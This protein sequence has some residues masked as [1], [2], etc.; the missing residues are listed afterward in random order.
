MGGLG[1]QAGN[2]GIPTRAGSQSGPG[3]MVS[4]VV[5]PRPSQRR[6]GV[7]RSE[8]GRAAELWTLLLVRTPTLRKIAFPAAGH[9]TS[10]EVES[11]MT[12]RSGV[13]LV[14]SLLAVPIVAVQVTEA[15]RSQQKV[16]ET[17]GRP[18]GVAGKVL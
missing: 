13:R 5:G 1:R 2:G 17:F 14:A 3:G 16:P 15:Q 9:P 8:P 4:T 18:S 7:R 10:G 11:S 6:V 12:G